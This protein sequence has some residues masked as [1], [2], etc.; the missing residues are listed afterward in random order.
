MSESRAKSYAAL[1]VGTVLLVLSGGFAALISPI[2]VM[3]SDGCMEPAERLICRGDVQQLVAFGPRV[4]LG[5][6]L[7]VGII[8]GLIAAYRRRS[9]GP[10]ILASWAIPAVA[11]AVAYTVATSGPSAEYEAKQRAEQAAEEQQRIDE[12]REHL[13]TAGTQE[14]VFPRYRK[15]IR[16]VRAG[17]LRSY[18]KLEWSPEDLFEYSIDDVRCRHWE[19][20]QPKSFDGWWEPYVPSGSADIDFDDEK[21]KR[22]F[23]RVVHTVGEKYGFDP[24]YADEDQVV[25]RDS[26]ETVLRV[27]FAE[28]GE[29][30]VELQSRCLLNEEFQQRLREKS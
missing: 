6:G 29:A 16:E 10:W 20:F 26:A 12:E 8:G 17:A 23:K 19:E 21:F 5:V 4:A 18:P 2:L 25:V 7:G 15:I 28:G 24:L 27:G 13:L 11:L 22:A 1:T 3:G 14:E 30:R 9:V